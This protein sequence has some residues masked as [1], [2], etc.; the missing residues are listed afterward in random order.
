MALW[1]SFQRTY[2]LFPAPAYYPTTIFSFKGSFDLCGHQTHMW[3]ANK[4]MD[5]TFIHI[6]LKLDI[7]RKMEIK[8][9][10]TRLSN[11]F[12]ENL[13]H[14]KYIL[15]IYNH[16]SSPPHLGSPKNIYFLTS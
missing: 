1:L 10:F 7:L 11:L 14:I 13:M 3:F 9:F 6:K 16:H 5:K 8:C 12:L 2:T 15:I 4:H